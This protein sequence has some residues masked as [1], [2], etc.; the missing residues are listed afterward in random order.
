VSLTDASPERQAVGAVLMIRPARFAA[1]AE[2]A[3]TNA[4]QTAGGDAERAAEAARR[5]HADLAG[6]LAAAGVRV[7]VVEG[8]PAADAPDELFP[9]NWVSLHA[10]GTAVLYPLLAPNRRLERRRDVLETLEKLHGYRLGRVV[11]LTALEEH[12]QFLEGTGSLVLDRPRRTAY[13]CL[14]P[15]TH[16]AALAAF[17]RA[18]DY[19]IVSFNAADRSGQAIYHTNVAMSLGTRFAVLCTEALPPEQRPPLLERLERSG[20]EIIEIGFPQLHAFAG[21]LLELAGAG[22]PVIA[23]SRTALASLTRA[24]AARLERHGALAVA[25]VGTIERHGGGGVRCML[26][27]VALPLSR[28]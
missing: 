6:R 15:R 14:S 11:D 20:R 1:N 23:L 4:F 7:H 5:E 10:D 2:T 19:E 26:C 21:N 28:P 27:E 24:Q 22:G 9:N 25:D 8:R 3:A 17:A 16:P 12:G 13:A 18:L